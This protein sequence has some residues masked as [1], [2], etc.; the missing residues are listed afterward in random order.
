MKILGSGGC[1]NGKVQLFAIGAKH[2]H[3]PARCEK[4]LHTE[5]QHAPVWLFWACLAHCCTDDQLV[6]AT[7]VIWIGTTL[8]EFEGNQATGSE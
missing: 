6:R 7:V 4:R 1:L 5:L 3:R 2:L 8:S